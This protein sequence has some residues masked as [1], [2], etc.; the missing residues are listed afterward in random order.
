MITYGNILISM[1]VYIACNRLSYFAASIVKLHL[2]K[3][4]CINNN[5]STK[6]ALKA[7]L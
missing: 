5:L 6:G 4:Q 2:I 1:C 7:A 3:S